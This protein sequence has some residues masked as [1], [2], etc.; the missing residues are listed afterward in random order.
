MK[1]RELLTAVPCLAMLPILPLQTAPMSSLLKEMFLP[2]WK[3]SKDFTLEVM[4][5][6]PS[7]SF[8][9][10]PHPEEMAFGQ[11]F[12]HLGYFNTFLLAKVV[13]ENTPFKLTGE[14]DEPEKEV[15]RK[16]LTETFDF[17]IGTL[18]QVK[19]S[20]LRETRQLSRTMSH[21]GAEMILRAYMHTAHH[22]GQSEVYLR[23]KG[24]KPPAF[25]F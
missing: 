3:V 18:E 7:T 20:E 19:E 22:R 8:N 24:I 1:R 11:L 16:F 2:H 9:F 17:T 12:M 14:K 21:T 4:E 6:M 23:L 5:A 15:V 10:R 13:G 25:K